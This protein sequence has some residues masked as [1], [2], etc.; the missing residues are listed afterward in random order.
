[1]KKFLAKIWYA[2]FGWTFKTDDATLEKST[3]CVMIAAPHTSNWDF[4]FAILGFWLKGLDLKFFIKDSYTNPFL[5]GG[6]FRWMGALG[7]DRSK[8][9][10]LV[11]HSVELLK[12]NKKLV[13]LVPA[14]GTRSRVEKW[15][16]GFYQI[17]VQAE[18]PITLGYLDFKKKEAGLGPVVYPTGDFEK[19]MQIIEDFYRHITGK[20]PE[21]YNPKIF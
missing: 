5:I 9:N 3:H 8:R 7:V 15:R 10:N 11:E 1:M 4:P 19:D 20:N 2:A 14:E 18:V 13:I 12:S 6:I 17:A 21:N 16:K